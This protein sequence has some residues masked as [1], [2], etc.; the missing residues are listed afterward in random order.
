MVKSL[1]HKKCLLILFLLLKVYWLSVAD[2]EGD[3]FADPWGDV[4]Y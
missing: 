1:L 4:A 2:N 3:D